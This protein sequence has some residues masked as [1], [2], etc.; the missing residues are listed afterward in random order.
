MTSFGG[1]RYKICDTPTQKWIDA[2][3]TCQ[4]MGANLPKV[5]TDAE[6]TFL[7]NLQRHAKIQNTW[8]AMTRDMVL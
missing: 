7:Y 8:M 2:Q 4:N 1:S 5:E 3:K 6:N